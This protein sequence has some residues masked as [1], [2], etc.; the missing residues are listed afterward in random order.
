MYNKMKEEKLSKTSQQHRGMSMQALRKPNRLVKA[1]L[2]KHNFG[3]FPN[4]VPSIPEDSSL[5]KD[6]F[7]SG[8]TLGP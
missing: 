6:D 3:I 1:A 4:Y 8:V 2:G 7:E 5:K